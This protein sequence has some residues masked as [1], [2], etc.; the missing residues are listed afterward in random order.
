MSFRTTLIEKLKMNVAYK[1]AS[2][3]TV[4]S[5]VT[6]II[7]D[8]LDYRDIASEISISSSDIADELDHHDLLSEVVDNLDTDE[9]AKAVADSC[10]LEDISSRVISMLPDSFM[11]DLAIQAAGEIIEEMK[12]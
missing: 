2:N 4:I 9:I 6:S 11:D 3:S 5:E 8:D 7:L 12:P 10:D 1:L